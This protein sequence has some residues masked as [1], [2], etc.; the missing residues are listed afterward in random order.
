MKKEVEKN[1]FFSSTHDQKAWV[2]NAVGVSNNVQD[3]KSSFE[4]N[5]KE[6]KTN[7]ESFA[8]T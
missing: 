2:T 4:A 8:M 3:N 5:W 1:P 6:S 7:R